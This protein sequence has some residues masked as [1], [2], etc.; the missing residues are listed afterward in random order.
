MRKGFFVKI[1]VDYQSASGQKT[2][3]GSAAE[4]M[5]RAMREAAP[6]IEFLLY[7]SN[8]KDLKTP[9]RLA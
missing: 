4:N 8:K 6:D 2:G 5:V 3:I 7:Q 1:A 9:R